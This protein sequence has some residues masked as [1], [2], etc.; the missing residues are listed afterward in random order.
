MKLKELLERCKVKVP[1][2]RITPPN[3]PRIDSKKLAKIIDEASEQY[4][5][6]AGTAKSTSLPNTI[7]K[8]IIS[9]S[10]EW[11]ER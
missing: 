1:E 11:M 8:S 5:T 7:F 10:S 3:Q 2:L 4:W 6:D 9:K